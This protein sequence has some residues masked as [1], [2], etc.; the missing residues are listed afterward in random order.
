MFVVKDNLNYNEIKKQ[1][2]KNIEYCKE[3]SKSKCKFFISWLKNGVNA[4]F[5]IVMIFTIIAFLILS[6]VGQEN[7]QNNILKILGVIANFIGIIICTSSL[8][9]L[10]ITNYNRVKEKT[11]KDIEINNSNLSEIDC[12]IAQTNNLNIKTEYEILKQKTELDQLLEDDNVDI[13]GVI[14]N[15]NDIKIIYKELDQPQN[16]LKEYGIKLDEMKYDDSI[17][18]PVIEFHNKKIIYIDQNKK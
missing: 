12:L 1:I 3:L 11:Q 2:K 7:T 14:T 10:N 17:K 5:T 13:L 15:K 4:A 18:E 16:N 9:Y 6:F 8:I